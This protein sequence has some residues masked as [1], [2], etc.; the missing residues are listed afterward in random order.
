MVWQGVT[1]HRAEKTNLGPSPFLLK[2]I[3]LWTFAAFII[4]AICC[5]MASG[6][7]GVYLHLR[8]GSSPYHVAQVCF[9][10]TVRFSSALLAFDYPIPAGC[11]IAICVFA[12]LSHLSVR[13]YF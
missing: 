4:R 1:V 8:Q 6:Q 12:D 11:K 5:H 10:R 13:F 7:L 9:S 3:T 2:L